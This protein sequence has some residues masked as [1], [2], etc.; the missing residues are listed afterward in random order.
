[1]QLK[2]ISSNIRYENPHDGNHAWEKRRPILQKIINDFHPDIL[3]TQEGREMQIK[4]LAQLLSLK[5]V[6]SHRDWITDRMY[7]CLYINEEQIKLNKSG[8]IWLSETPH[9]NGSIS[10][11]SSFPRLCTW[12]HVT[13]LV[14]NQDYF[15]VN[16]HLDHVLEETRIHQVNVL[17]N[18][19][20]KLN[21]QRLPLILMGDFNDSPMSAIRKTILEKLHLK[22]PW[23][24][25]GHSEETSHHGFN[26]T[27]ANG[28][29]IDWILVPEVFAVENIRLEKSS[30]ENIF[31]SDHYP[32]LA[33]VIPR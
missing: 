25:L 20:Q 7:P 21:Q 15:V 31:P 5:L 16:T 6:E 4:S 29:R 12:M 26:G 14:N 8:D 32:L 2:I 19:I 33:T 27:A 10:F 9:V 1:M 22:D 17:T 18:E 30:F 11:K 13:H 28:D 3:G 24:E 23:I